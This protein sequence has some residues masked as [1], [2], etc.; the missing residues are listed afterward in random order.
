MRRRLDG[1]LLLDKP[2]GISSNA[3]LQEAK[4]LCGARKA[5]HAGTLDPLAT[6]LLPLLFGEATKFSQF[7]LESD[8]EY[9][10]EA[11]LGVTTSTGD[12]EGAVIERRAVAI[13][14]DAIE[15]ALARLRGELEQIPP[16][17]SALK[18]GGRPLYRLAREGASV[19]RAPRRVVVHE[20]ER[21]GREGDL[22]RLRVR[23]SKG[24]Y[25]RTLVEDLGAALGTGAHLA[26]LRRTAAG[27]FRVEAALTL[28]GLAELE[29]AARERQVL[30]LATLLE[31]LPSVVLPAESAVRFR[32]GQAVP[33]PAALRGRCQVCDGEG[34]LLGV[35]E[36][37]ADGWLRPRRLVASD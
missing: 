7:L 12:A 26:A 14:E 37:A 4:R 13:A 19:E 29:P 23:C 1:L 20:L 8:K 21:L 33:Q 27:R 36:L 24:T 35:G 16:M 11:R 9:L 15:Q 10:A 17:H 34:R 2:A 30:P 31:G 22:L 6:G 25:I 28:Q 5:G 32:Q 3:A 18:R